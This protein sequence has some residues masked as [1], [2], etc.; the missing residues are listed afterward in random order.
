VATLDEMVC[1]TEMNEYG[2]MCVIREL[3]WSYKCYAIFSLLD[4]LVG[5]PGKY[6][7]YLCNVPNLLYNFFALNW[8]W[9]I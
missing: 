7:I 5:I 8:K 9:D 1:A 3:F 4:V 2:R 6:R